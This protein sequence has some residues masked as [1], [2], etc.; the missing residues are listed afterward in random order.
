MHGGLLGVA[1]CLSVLSLCLHKMKH[2]SHALHHQN[3]KSKGM[4]WWGSAQ[5]VCQHRGRG[6]LW[7]GHGKVMKFF[8][9]DFVATLYKSL[10]CHTLFLVFVGKERFWS[11]RI[12][13]CHSACPGWHTLKG[14]SGGPR[15]CIW[16]PECSLTLSCY[17]APDPT[18]SMNIVIL[19]KCV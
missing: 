18:K 2:I 3:T 5:C 8:R 15:H 12:R 19:L 7:Y 16:T 9:E 11:L 10:M 13:G 17:L 14:T 6:I 4:G 1:F